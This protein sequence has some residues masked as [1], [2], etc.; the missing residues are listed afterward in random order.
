MTVDELLFVPAYGMASHQGR[1]A[2]R[3]AEYSNGFPTRAKHT[4]CRTASAGHV[5][6]G[7][8]WVVDMDL[9]KLFDR[10]KHDVLMS[11]IARRVS[12]KRVL[13]L[14]RRYLQ[15]GM[16]QG[17][18]VSV[19]REGTVQGGPLSPLLAN[20]LLHELDKEPETLDISRVATPVLCNLIHK[21]SK[22]ESCLRI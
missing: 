12:D 19:R 17:G 7:K 21:I 10:V 16:M 5:S 8:R 6:A 18:L 2:E 20:M 3:N 11:R 1:T 9:E 13:R 15:A 22:N 14:V 4:R